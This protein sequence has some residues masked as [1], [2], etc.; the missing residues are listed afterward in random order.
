MI[1]DLLDRH[2]DDHRPDRLPRV[3]VQESN[4][5][6]QCSADDRTEKRNHVEEARQNPD[7]QPEGQIDDPHADARGDADY[8]RHK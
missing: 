2:E 7:Q 5:N 4:E 3:T 1:V 6:S 8:H